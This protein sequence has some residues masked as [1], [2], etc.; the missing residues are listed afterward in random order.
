[1]A[2]LTCSLLQTPPQLHSCLITDCTDYAIPFFYDLMEPQ[3]GPLFIISPGLFPFPV[4]NVSNFQL[5]LE[6]FTNSYLLTEGLP[7]PFFH[8][9]TRTSLWGKE[10]CWRG[11]LWTE[12]FFWE[13]TRIPVCSSGRIV[14]ITHVIDLTIFCLYISSV[15]WHGFLGWYSGFTGL[16][17]P[18]TQTL[19][20]FS[21]SPDSGPVLH[22][23]SAAW[24]LRTLP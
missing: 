13:S 1:M 7:S 18:P 3:T 14:W 24:W 10:S 23:I 11:R 12:A 2:T 5:S 17:A 6:P 19:A 20:C 9:V 22:Y 15:L 8:P 4:F 21:P 16:L